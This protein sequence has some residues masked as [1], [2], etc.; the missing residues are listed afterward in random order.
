MANLINPSFAE[1][2][3]DRR[4]RQLEDY[5]QAQREPAPA[6]PPA[7]PPAEAAEPDPVAETEAIEAA[8]PVAAPAAP[9]EQAQALLEKPAEPEQKQL[10]AQQYQD[11]QPA[12]SAPAP[13]QSGTDKKGMFWA[14]MA[15]LMLNRG[16]NIGGIMV[17]ANK[18]RPD[19]SLNNELKRAQIERLRGGRVGNPLE[20]ERL[21]IQQAAETRKLAAANRLDERQNPNSDRANSVRQMLYQRGVSADMT[22]LS[23]DDMIKTNPAYK[24]EIENFYAG[25]KAKN[26]ALQ[27]GSTKTAQLDA[28]HAVAPRSAGDAAQQAGAVSTATFGDRAQLA[29]I[30]AAAGMDRAKFEQA[31]RRAIKDEGYGQ[32]F[33]KDQANNLSIIGLMQDVQNTPGGLV[34]Q[35]LAERL[36]DKSTLMA[37]GID[38]ARMPAV[39]AKRMIM[40]KWGREQSGAAISKTED[41]RFVQQVGA[42]PMAS[43]SEINAAFGTLQNLVQRDIAGAMAANPAAA[44][45]VLRAR[46]IAPEAILP[47]HRRS[48]PTRPAAAAPA[49]SAEATPEGPSTASRNP[50]GTWDIDEPGKDPQ[51]NKHLSDSFIKRLEQGGWRVMR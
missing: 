40:E 7:E 2:E 4:M 24:Q 34:P 27:A 12:A 41:G 1:S 51:L 44:D 46:G 3:E 8:A 14:S 50:D 26:A 25:D 38:S 9:Q 45:P 22:G 30:G 31:D 28:E 18:P 10:W 15:D 21:R 49:A 13:A 35:S 6:P 32:Q 48:S 16:R 19:A 43:E 23:V 47:A 33:N 39:V 42:N 17:E 36:A 29:A 20:A 5:Y 37:N 11:M